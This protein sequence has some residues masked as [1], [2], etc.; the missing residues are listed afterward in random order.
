MNL[1]YCA[2]LVMFP[3]CIKVRGMSHLRGFV[4]SKPSE[5]TVVS[6]GC[7]PLASVLGDSKKSAFIVRAWPP[8]ILEIFR[9][10][11]FSKVSNSVVRPISTYVVSVLLR[12]NAIH[13]KPRESMG[14][15]FLPGN[16]YN[17]IPLVIFRAGNFPNS[18]SA[19]SD[20]PCK[21]SSFW[22]VIKQL[23]ESFL[24]G[25]RMLFSHAVVPYKQWFGQRPARVIST[26]GLR[27]F[28]A[29]TTGGKA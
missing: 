27:Y 5:N 11:G 9:L 16:L 1:L 12:P 29:Y 22:F 13:V 21:N 20:S 25:Y 15:V 23:F 14:S 26:G 6:D 18:T 19:R 8:L 3:L 2:E 17:K 10:C 4:D 7:P 28:T 24:G